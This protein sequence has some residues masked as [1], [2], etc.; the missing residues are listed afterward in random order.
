MARSLSSTNPMTMHACF[1]VLCVPRALAWRK[2]GTLLEL[3][4]ELEQHKQVQ[5]YRPF[6]DTIT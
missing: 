4:R 2:V 1:E 3:Y 6:L 5:H